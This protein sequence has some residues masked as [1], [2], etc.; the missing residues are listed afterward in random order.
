MQAGKRA[1]PETLLPWFDLLTQMV[2][3]EPVAVRGAFNFGL[4]SIVKGM[5]A[6]GLIETTWTD[7]PTDGLGA[8]IGAWW[9]DA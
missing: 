3:A 1:S 4:K 7:G 5:H 9:C 6:A 2:R 8:M